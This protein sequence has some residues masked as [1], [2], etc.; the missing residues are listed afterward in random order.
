MQ[1]SELKFL[2]KLL[3]RE[4]YRAPSVRE[5]AP[6]SKTSA[7]EVEKICR[8]LA[9]REIVGYA[10]VIRK[11]EI[12]SAGKALLQQ[13]LSQVPVSEQQLIVLKACKTKAIAPS[14]ISSKKLPAQ[15][16]QL[17][18][19]D[20]AQKGLVKAKKVEIKEVWLT[21]R[22]AEYLRDELNLT[23]IVKQFD[24]KLF[25][26]YLNFMR[27]LM[28]SSEIPPELPPPD[29]QA[30]PTDEEIL[31]TIRNLDR[32][33]GTENYLP[34]FYLRKKLQPPLSRDELDQAL[35]RLQRQDKLDLSSLVEAIHYTSEE[36]QAGIPQ[37]SGGPLFF[38]VVN[39]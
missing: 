33:L 21:D 27:K 4:S 25:G 7:S 20:L 31:Q 26:N 35:Y 5:L 10:Y 13:D 14:D 18:I 34:I 9:E 29:G 17:V 22:G 37:E 2:L 12:E 30:K 11:F 24:L 3:G 38:L 6:S 16:R 36:I 39:E 8:N 15:D 1:T 23:G 28:R 19:Q 32:E